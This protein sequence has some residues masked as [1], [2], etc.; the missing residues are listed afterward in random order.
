MI[1]AKQISW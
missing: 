1:P